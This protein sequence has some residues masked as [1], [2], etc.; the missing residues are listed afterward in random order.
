MPYKLEV[1]GFNI[2][3]CII[4]RENG[5]DRIELCNNPADGGTTP[6][7]GFIYAARKAL[8]IELYPIIRPRGGDFLYSDN[9]YLIMKK[10]V[11]LCKEA[12]CD[13]IVTGMLNN[14]GSID[15]RRTGR[16]VELAYPM[17]V[18]F[19]RAFDRTAD[20]YAALEDIIDM[21]CERIL[22]S[23]LCSTALEGIEL[24]RRLVAQ[25]D[26]RIIMMPG[27]GVRSSN[28]ETFIKQTGATEFHTSARSQ[29]ASMMKYVNNNIHEETQDVQCD[30]EEVKRIVGILNEFN[31]K[32]LE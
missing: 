24:I 25:A 19:H 9:E 2:A 32:N 6:S 30:G 11:A 23:G 12:G 29:V 13:G 7:C 14:D 3:S 28:I 4:A 17:S 15:K 18:S 21:G 20:P 5:A 8:M 27:S 10:D 16:L 1:I 22:T 31:L 26:Q